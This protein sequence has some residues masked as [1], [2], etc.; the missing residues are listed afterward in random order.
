MNLWD[1]MS[2]EIR[3]L[4]EAKRLPPPL[5]RKELRKSG[6]LTQADLAA[7]VG[8]TKQTIWLWEADRVKP[9]GMNLL[10]YSQALNELKDLL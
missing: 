7:Q 8:V 1:N 4:V 6:G 9:R 2:Q 5:L 3:D 10:R